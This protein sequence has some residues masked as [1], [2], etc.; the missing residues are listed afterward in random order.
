M[1][2]KTQIRDLFQQY[3][4]NPEDIRY[5]PNLNY[6][7]VDIGVEGTDNR[8]LEGVGELGSD[9][10]VEQ[11]VDTGALRGVAGRIDGA[12]IADGTVDLMSVMEDSHF[13]L[14]IE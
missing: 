7:R 13:Q 5:N 14:Q 12:Q 9:E 1:D 6:Y 10:A 3:G 2:T 11:T 8:F 4:I